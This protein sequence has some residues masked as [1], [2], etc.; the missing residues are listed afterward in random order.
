MQE[1]EMKIK[2]DSD[3]QK[4]V[5]Y[6]HY[7]MVMLGWPKM[8]IR[9]VGSAMKPHADIVDLFKR[10]QEKKGY[11]VTITNQTEQ[12]YGNNTL[13]CTHIHLEGNY[14]NVRYRNDQEKVRQKR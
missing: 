10:N 1:G 13:L 6:L 14:N 8:Q 4:N 7:R 3:V 11:I 9:S 5:G 12:I 2:T